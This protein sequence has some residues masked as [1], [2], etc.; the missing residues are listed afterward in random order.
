MPKTVLDKI[1]S[2]IDTLADPLGASRPAIAKCVKETH[3]ELSAALLKKALAQGVTKGKLIQQGQRFSI[4]GVIIAPAEEVMVQKTV[5][6]PGDSS[7][8]AAEGDE[9]DVAYKG[10]LDSDGSQFDRAAH[11]KFT[12]GAGDVIK[13]WDRGVLGMCVGERARLVVPPK[14]GYGKRGSGSEIPGDSTLIFDIT[15]NR[16]L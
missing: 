4:P 6:K 7:Q 9:V 15:L 3:G 13:G 1:I 5:I 16:I 8:C 11:F 10:T 14:L 2:A 12:L